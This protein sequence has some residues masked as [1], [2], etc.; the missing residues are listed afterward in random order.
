M[1]PITEI[2][3]ALNEYLRRRGFK[4]EQCRDVGT[5]DDN[6]DVLNVHSWFPA[7][8]YSDV[9]FLNANK[10]LKKHNTGQ[11]YNLLRK[12]G[13]PIK[14]AF[15]GQTY[16]KVK[17]TCCTDRITF[18]YDGIIVCNEISLSSGRSMIEEIIHSVIGIQNT[19]TICK[20]FPYADPGFVLQGT[21][22]NCLGKGCG[23]CEWKGYLNL[24]A[25]GIF[26]PN[27]LS[28][29]V[30]I[31]DCDAVGF[32]FCFNISKI[33]FLKYGLLDIHD[34]FY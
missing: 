32:S 7:R 30:A 11:I 24:C 29:A 5:L 33:A 18:Q 25:Y 21:C 14:T 20:F 22:P 31:E 1:H 26:H 19:R 10:I 12:Q 4:I 13:V 2:E 34:L 15:V 9:C 3:F 28:T 17:E 16:R 6:F 23:R 8:T 27:V